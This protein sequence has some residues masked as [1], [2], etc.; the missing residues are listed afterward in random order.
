MLTF[1]FMMITQTASMSLYLYQAKT[2]AM[3]WSARSHL[4]L[5]FGWIAMALVIFAGLLGTVG[6]LLRHGRTIL[7]GGVLALASMA[8][9][10]VG[11]QSE[12]WKAPINPWGYSLPG[13]FSSGSINLGDLSSVSYT[14]YLSFG[15][16]ITLV[17][18]IIMLA[19]SRTRVVQSPPQPPPPS[20]PSLDLPFQKPKNRQKLASTRYGSGEARA[21]S[22]NFRGHR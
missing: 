7:V 15:F 12:L 9:F 1:S 22:E 2:T 10:A 18:A 3:D 20:Q 4:S 8:V 19:A 17:A 21:N 14:T 13:I 6:G 5:W 11:L 16:W